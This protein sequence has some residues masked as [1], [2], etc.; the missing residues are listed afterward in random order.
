M[1]YNFVRRHQSL[2][3]LTPAMRLRE[4]TDF[5]EMIEAFEARH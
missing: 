3:K 4:M 1:Y 2:K 5:V